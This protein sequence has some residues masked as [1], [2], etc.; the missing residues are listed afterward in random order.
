MVIIARVNMLKLIEMKKIVLT[1]FVLL[2]LFSGCGRMS[3]SRIKESWWL[4]GSGYHVGDALRFDDDNLKG[5]TI[6]KEKEPVAII[7]SCE[8]GAFYKTAVLKIQDIETGNIGTYH[9]K[10]PH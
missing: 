10:G 1:L 5:D 4:H 6:Y 2:F 7:L 3:N 8:N 9:D